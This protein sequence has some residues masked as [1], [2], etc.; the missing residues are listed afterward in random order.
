MFYS[1]QIN[2]IGTKLC[3]YFYTFENGGHFKICYVKFLKNQ[4]PNENIYSH[5]TLFT[6]CHREFKNTSFIKVVWDAT[7]LCLFLL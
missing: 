4:C 5:T 1:T 3:K 6:K 2:F 7:N